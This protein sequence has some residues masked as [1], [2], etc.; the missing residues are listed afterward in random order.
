V[1][2]ELN[3]SG[4][5]AG[6]DLMADQFETEVHEVLRQCLPA[7]KSLPEVVSSDLRL[8]EDLGIDELHMVRL[9][10]ELED[11]FKIEISDERSRSIETIGDLVR[12]V[13]DLAA[14]APS[15]GLAAQAA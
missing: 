1:C 15:Q 9:M 4:G 6:R 14:D 11:S 8:R 10:V 13:V 7:E 12:A 2:L 5:F 3:F